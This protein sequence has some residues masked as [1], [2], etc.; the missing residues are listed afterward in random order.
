MVL[1]GDT[2]PIKI[3]AD[4]PAE[5]VLFRSNRTISG[6]LTPPL[7]Y[8]LFVDPLRYAA[9]ASLELRKTIGRIVGKIN[10][11]PSVKSNGVIMMGPGRW[12]SNNID[13]GVNVTYADIN[14]TKVL[15][16]MASEE[17][18]QLPEVSYGTHFFLDLVEANIIYMPVYPGDP[19]A[20]FNRTLF[21]SLPNVLTDLLPEAG[22][23]REVVRVFDLPKS[24]GRSA[25]VVADPHSRM[26][27]C[28][29]E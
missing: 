22:R 3:P 24:T 29:L 28:Y 16:E 2:G 4:L 15:V 11:Q 9:A 18:G 27:I 25:R 13:L 23:Y 12:G 19:E 21:D 1:P 5:R 20:A 14:N 6:G 7:R 17:A 8:L 10:E 26:A